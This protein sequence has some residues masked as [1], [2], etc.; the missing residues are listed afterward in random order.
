M[1]CLSKYLPA[2]G[3]GAGVSVR[4]PQLPCA[5]TTMAEPPVK[6]PAS[7][8]NVG[9]WPTTSITRSMNPSERCVWG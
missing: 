3:R 9:L 4:H 5:R 6:L 2:C 7:T 1:L 8:Q